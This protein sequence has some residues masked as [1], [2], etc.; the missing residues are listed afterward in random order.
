ME[1]CKEDFSFKGEVN[2]EIFSSKFMNVFSTEMFLDNNI[3]IIYVHDTHCS[4]YSLV[5]FVLGPQL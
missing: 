3:H 2:L 5:L 4:F 1:E